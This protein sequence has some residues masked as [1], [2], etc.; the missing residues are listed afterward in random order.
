MPFPN[1]PRVIY[2][3]NPLAEVVCALQ[4]PPILK[5][6]L[7]TPAEF[8]ER[9]RFDY[10]LYKLAQPPMMNLPPN[11]PPRVAKLL[12][13]F[14]PQQGIELSHEFSSEDRKWQIQLTRDV[15]V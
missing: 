8:Q 15:I 14:G 4:F 13:G 12:S 7:G 1:S 11:I 10:P 6:E 9:I 2:K 3:K 5:I